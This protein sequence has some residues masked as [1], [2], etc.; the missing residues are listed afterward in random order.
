MA[1]QHTDTQATD[2]ATDTQA[3]DTQATD[4]KTDRKTAK[5]VAS[6]HCQDKH[7]GSCGAADDECAG[8]AEDHR[9]LAAHG[10]VETPNSRSH[11]PQKKPV[12]VVFVWFSGPG[13]FLCSFGV[14]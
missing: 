11:E 6:N 9:G 14:G 12:Q 4:T 10:P 1:F 7:H 3:T 8:R 5:Y 13:F 2:T